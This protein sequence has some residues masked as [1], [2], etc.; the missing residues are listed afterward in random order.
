LA[1][2]VEM[3]RACRV[4]LPDGDEDDEAL[5]SECGMQE[6]RGSFLD[7]LLYFKI[8]T[9]LVAMLKKQDKMSM[10]ASIETRVPYLDHHLVRLAFSMGTPSKVRGR[11]GKPLLR[12]ASRGV[13]P[14]AVIDRPK[15]GFPVPIASWLRAPGNPFI[16]MLLE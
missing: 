15:Q 6:R 10:A 16:A 12:D 11:S 14:D 4:D 1:S 3:R 5:F 8:K 13:L 2:H 9:Y 7:R